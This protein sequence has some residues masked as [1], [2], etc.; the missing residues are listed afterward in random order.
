MPKSPAPVL[1]NFIL[2]AI[3][4]W[5]YIL[6]VKA[7]PIINNSWFVITP[8]IGYFY[9]TF[10]FIA[11]YY[12]HQ[13]KRLGLGLG[14][15]V[16]LFGMMADVFSYSLAWQRFPVIEFMIIPLIVVNTIQILYM[17]YHQQNYNGS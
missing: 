9:F 11:A 5:L 3:I 8:I 1:L 14:C 12:M 6:W 7:Q 13:R 15:C 17:A 4:D 16:L 2:L 10:A